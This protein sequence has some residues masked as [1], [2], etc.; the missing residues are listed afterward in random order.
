MRMS[1]Q[2]VDDALKEDLRRIVVQPIA[3]TFERLVAP[4]LVSIDQLIKNI[5]ED[6]SAGSKHKQAGLLEELIVDRCDELT[7]PPHCIEAVSYILRELVRN[8]QKYQIENT[9]TKVRASTRSVYCGAKNV[10]VIETVISDAGPEEAINE[11]FMR[12]LHRAD[13]LHIGWYI[14]GV[15]VRGLG[16]QLNFDRGRGRARRRLQIRLPV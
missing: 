8:A 7:L 16:G 12:P 10:L 9:S 15:L 14:I 6:E 1:S 11:A 13:R 4:D 2:I 3:S 5:I